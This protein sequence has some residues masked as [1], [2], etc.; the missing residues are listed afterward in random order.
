MDVS[1]DIDIDLKSLYTEKTDDEKRRISDAIKASVMFRNITD[2][3][4]EMVFGVME[5]VHKPD[6][7]GFAAALMRV[8]LRF[9]LCHTLVID[10]ASAFFGVFRK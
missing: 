4:R 9:G 10:K 8:L 3:Q 7:K 2:E 1:P 6:A 5:S